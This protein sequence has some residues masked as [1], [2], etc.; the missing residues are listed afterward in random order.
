MRVSCAARC[1]VYTSTDR[2]VQPN[3]LRIVNINT[4]RTFFRFRIGN[5]VCVRDYDILVRVIACIRRVRQRTRYTTC[6][7]TLGLAVGFR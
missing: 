6:M 2:M 5:I 3:P 4:P 7:F 1:F